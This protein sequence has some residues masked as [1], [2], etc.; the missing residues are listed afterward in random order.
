M[1]TADRFYIGGAWVAPSGTRTMPI[2]TPST[3]ARIGTLTLGNAE[4]VDRAVAAARTAFE[5]YSLTPKPERL[6][7]LRRLAG[8]TRARLDDL[9]RAISAEMGAPATMAREVQA[10]SGLGHL[11]GFIAALEALDEEETLPNGDILSREP[12]GVCGLITPWNWP[13]NQIALKVVPVL[14][15]GATCVLKPSEHTPL[16]A[17]IYAEMV[18]EA[19]FPAGVFN[20]VHGEGPTV[21]A[22][23]SRHPDVAMMS[24]TGSTRAGSAVSRDAAATI[25]RV[26]LELGGKSP[27]LVFADCDLDAR[28][29]EGVA[30]CFYNTGQS[31]DAP[32]RMLVERSVYDRALEIARAAAEAQPVGDPAEEG[33]HIGPLFDRLQYD[34]VQTMIRKGLD[35]GARLLAGG[36]GRPDGLPERLQGG[37]FVRPTVF[38]DVSPDMAIWREEI[39]GPVLAMTPF[40]SEEEAIALANDTDYG[41]AAY[42]QTGSEDRAIR[43][44]RR[45]RA[46]GIHINGRDADY[47]SP[48]GGFRQ[49]GN[50]REGG[51]F[52]LED[53]LEM[54]VRPPFVA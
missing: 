37:W 20:L 52:G 19:G 22:A 27:N 4:D 46:G 18:H 29:T 15:T 53:Y 43:V 42:I 28:V 23:L 24:F 10:Y 49:S 44:A 11:E 25:K 16:S 31:C 39:F 12:I 54:K 7:L 50:G 3:N 9:G 32:T 17:Q 1:I 36:P 33:D 47:G 26:T 5:S 21:G 51:R 13:I 30:A 45:L 38:C 34:R 14:A 2:L 6:A 40:D 8:I 35:D 48:F 41:L